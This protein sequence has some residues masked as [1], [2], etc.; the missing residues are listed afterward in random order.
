MLDAAGARVAADVAVHGRALFAEFGHPAERRNARAAGGREMFERD[1]H[2]GRVGVV[3]VVDDGGAVQPGEGE[4]PARQRAGEGAQTR[5]DARG[6]GPGCMRGGR[7]GR[8][9]G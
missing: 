1:A 2:G 3:T 9:V 6:G 8:G 5:A 4:Q 7:G